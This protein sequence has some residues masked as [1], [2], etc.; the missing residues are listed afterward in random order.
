[1]TEEKRNRLTAAITVAAILLIVVLAA[2]IIYQLI[3]IA[4]LTDRRDE[5]KSQINDYE[6]KIEN[7]DTSLE[8]YQSRDYLLD[9]A[10]EFGFVYGD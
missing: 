9:K 2:V 4:I 10:L 8:Y 7:A 1:M 6:K 3:D 5:I